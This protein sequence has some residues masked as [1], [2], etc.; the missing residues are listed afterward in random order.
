VGQGTVWQLEFSGASPTLI[1]GPQALPG[2][3]ARGSGSGPVSFARDIT[4][5]APYVIGGEATLK[6]KSVWVRWRLEAAGN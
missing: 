5:T 4:E 1:F 3:G 6:G 2:L